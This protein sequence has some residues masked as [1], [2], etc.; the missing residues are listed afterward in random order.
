MIYGVSLFFRS[1]S[2][3]RILLRD[4]MGMS[5]HKGKE[6][7]MNTME[8]AVKVFDTGEE[9]TVNGMVAFECDN[10]VSFY[11]IDENDRALWLNNDGQWVVDSERANYEYAEHIDGISGADDEEVEDSVNDRLASYGFRLGDFDEEHGDRYFL[12]SL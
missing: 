3:V 12:V 4:M 2:A 5:I 6:L 7:K 9:A 10:T 1:V 8:L 11:F